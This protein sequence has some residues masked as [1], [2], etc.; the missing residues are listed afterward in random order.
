MTP[1]IFMGQEWSADTPFQYFTDLEPDLGQLVTAG[2]RL[3][4]VA[5]PE[6]S[7]ESARDRIPDPQSAST[8]DASRLN[9]AEPDAPDHGAVL[10]VY[11]ALLALRLD[12]PALGA[13]D[14]T[15]G[16]AEAPDERSLVIR[17]AE[18]GEVF[19]VAAQMKGAGSIDLARLAEARGEPEGE[20]TVVLSTE[21]PLY[22]I[23]PQPPQID[24]Q[25]GGPVVHFTRPG[26]VIFRRT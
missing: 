5:F 19:W 9:W 25:P 17:S 1:L 13:S 15:A 20:W 26:A 21:E 11:R 6:F 8:L 23:I 3:E 10:A 18:H 2:R 24:S 4:F 16:D 12:H 7:N 22:A 14:E